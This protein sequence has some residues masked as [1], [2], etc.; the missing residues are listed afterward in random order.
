[1][2]RVSEVEQAALLQVLIAHKRELRKFRGVQAVDVGF[3]FVDGK[4]TDELAIR[5]HVSEKIPE[6]TLD[7]PQVLPLRS[8]ACRST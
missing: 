2:R 3:K 4:P 6:N 1:M 7:A 8:A 5:V